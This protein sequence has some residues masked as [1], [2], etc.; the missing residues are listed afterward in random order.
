MKKKKV[1][2]SKVRTT[3]EATKKEQPKSEKRPPRKLQKRSGEK[4]LLLLRNNTD[5]H[6]KKC[7]EKSLLQGGG[8]GYTQKTFLLTY[9]QAAIPHKANQGFG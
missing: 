2:P 7:V 1:S 4:I 8:V 9:Q 6:P 3:A 5:Y